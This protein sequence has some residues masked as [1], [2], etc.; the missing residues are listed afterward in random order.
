MTNYLFGLCDICTLKED[1]WN[2]LFATANYVIHF[3]KKYVFEY[4]EMLKGLHIMYK[5]LKKTLF[6]DREILNF[7]DNLKMNYNYLTDPSEKT[8][9][10]FYSKIWKL[11][12]NEEITKQIPRNYLDSETTNNIIN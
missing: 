9:E 6:N 8:L 7:L 11:K 5:K 3:E 1:S 4:Y 12:I 2:A 10:N